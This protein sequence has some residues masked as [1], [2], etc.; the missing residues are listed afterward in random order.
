MESQHM[1][2]K[3]AGNMAEIKIKSLLFAAVNV[4]LIAAGAWAI[5]L[6]A[7]R[8]NSRTRFI[9]N[10]VAWLVFTRGWFWFGGYKKQEAY[11]L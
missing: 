6:R 3:M 7:D 4:R 11:Y 8:V 2:M 9:I 10:P 5:E 1:I